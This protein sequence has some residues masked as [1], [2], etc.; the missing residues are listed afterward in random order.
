MQYVFTGNSLKFKQK[1]SFGPSVL[2]S[3]QEAIVDSERF[4]NER[5]EKHNNCPCLR[6]S[7][8]QQPSLVKHLHRSTRFSI[9]TLKSLTK[10]IVYMAWTHDLKVNSQPLIKHLATKHTLYSYWYIMSLVHHLCVP[11]KLKAS[12]KGNLHNHLSSHPC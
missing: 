6:K 10:I 3:S 1:L 8:Q 2:W 5:Y 7:E 9:N 12:S 11:N 4:Q